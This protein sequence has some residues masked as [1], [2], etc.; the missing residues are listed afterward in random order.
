M[1]YLLGAV[2]LM[3]AA[4][5]LIGGL[6]DEQPA[7]APEAPPDCLDVPVVGVQVPEE[8]A[9]EV[10]ARIAEEPAPTDARCLPEAPGP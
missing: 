6:D 3:L 5:M 9:E 10:A 1:K 4:W 8:V 2:A 7:D